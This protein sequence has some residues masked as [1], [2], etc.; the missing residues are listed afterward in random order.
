M[1][2][3]TPNSNV[4]D[5]DLEIGAEAIA[6]NIFKGR[7]RPRQVYRMAERGDWPFFRILNKLAARPSA[8]RAEMA[9]REAEAIRRQG[10]QQLELSLTGED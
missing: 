2:P 4:L 6:Q 3:I 8:M 5:D 9:R 10:G 1:E 7:V